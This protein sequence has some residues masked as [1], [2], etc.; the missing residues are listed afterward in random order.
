M[1][2]RKSALVAHPAERLYRL[3]EAAEE[4]PQFLPWCSTVTL[5][6]RD[7]HSVSAR[8]EVAWRGVR[9]NLVT[10]NQKRHPH[11]MSLKLEHGPFKRFEGEWRLT[12][13]AE[14]GCRVEFVLQYEFNASLLGTLAAPVFEHAANTL[15]DAFVRRADEVTVLPPLI[16][17]SP[18]APPPAPVP[19]AAPEA[20]PPATP[21]AAP[22]SL[23]S[24]PLQE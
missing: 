6:H 16:Y 12:P 3:I 24:Q 5:L 14:W 11:W 2:V 18:A 17:T 10:V 19:T 7:E 9:F 15:V 20:A 1:E 23:S 4:Y 21:G 13:L 22:D 8:L